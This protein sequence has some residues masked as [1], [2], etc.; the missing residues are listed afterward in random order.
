MGVL[1]GQFVDHRDHNGLNNRREN[2]RIATH[3]Q[4]QWNQ[5]KT[6]RPTTSR[7]KGVRR[8]RFA[9]RPE[10]SFNDKSLYLGSFR[11]EEAAARAY[12]AKALEL[13]GEFASLNV[14]P[15]ETPPAALPA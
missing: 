9:W 3:A 8:T 15:S 6:D 12:N 4:N 2:L 10:I 5:I 1:P 14:I 13:F 7:Y 11:T